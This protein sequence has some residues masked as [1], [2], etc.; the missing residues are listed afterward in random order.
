MAER[1]A[2]SPPPAAARDSRSGFGLTEMLIS[3]TLFALALAGI[4]GTAAQVGAGINGAHERTRALT[5]AQAQL[6]VLLTQPYEE[7][8]DGTAE[9]SGVSMNWTVSERDGVKEIELV[10]RHETPQKALTRTL[11]AARLE[12]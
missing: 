4:A 11:T 12:R 9:S 3:T 6:E 8:G 10:F 7:L 2:Q 5:V 1:R